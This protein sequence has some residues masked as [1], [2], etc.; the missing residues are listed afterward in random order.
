[1]IKTYFKS[2]QWYNITNSLLFYNIKYYALYKKEKMR[3][4]NLK[5]KIKNLDIIMPKFMKAYSAFYN[6]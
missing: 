3:S 4:K 2:E 5:V 6:F 1:M